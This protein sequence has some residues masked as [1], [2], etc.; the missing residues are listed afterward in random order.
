M[1]VHLLKP[2]H[3]WHCPACGGTDTTHEVQPHSRMH[4]CPALGGL[5][6]PMASG[7]SGARLV[8]NEREDYVGTEDVTVLNGRP[9]MSITTEYPDGHTDLAVLAPTAH[10]TGAAH[11]PGR[12]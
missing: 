2:T 6:T 4:T 5:S 3:Y 10:A 8:V 11:D 12:N 9:V 7:R 1:T